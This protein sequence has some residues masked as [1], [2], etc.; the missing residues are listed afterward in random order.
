M[1]KKPSDQKQAEWEERFREAEA[2][3][4][5]VA[6]YC[7][8]KGI[9]RERFYWW[10]RRIRGAGRGVRGE[11]EFARVEVMPVSAP[12]SPGSRLPDPKWLAEFLLALS[13]GS[14]R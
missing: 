11:R 9:R 4:G 7:Q 14:A 3:A 1:M 2:H 12:A 5:G 13:E 8:E 10:R 6:G